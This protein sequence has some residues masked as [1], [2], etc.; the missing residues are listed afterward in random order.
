[1]GIKKKERCNGKETTRITPRW[2]EKARERA[3]SGGTSQRGRK[4]GGQDPV[5]KRF[6]IGG[7]EDEKFT[8]FFPKRKWEAI[9]KNL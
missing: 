6:L 7:G 8:S 9:L 1:L 4:L 2:E 3:L 5:G